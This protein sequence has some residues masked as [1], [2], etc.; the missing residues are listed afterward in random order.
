MGLKNRN[1]VKE[2][3]DSAAQSLIGSSHKMYDYGAV[4]DKDRNLVRE[5]VCQ[6]KANPLKILSFKRGI[7]KVKKFIDSQDF[8]NVKSISDVGE[9]LKDCPGI[10]SL[11][12]DV[13]FDSVEEITSLLQQGGND[14]GKN[15]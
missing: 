15:D 14:D 10:G 5:L 6:L 11:V 2:E 3:K 1:Y 8:S 4:D 12:K 9:V 13:D 7:N